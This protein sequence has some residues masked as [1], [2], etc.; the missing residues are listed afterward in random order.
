MIDATPPK[1]HVLPRRA[2]IAVRIGV[3]GL[4]LGVLVVGA[5][6][7]MNSRRPLPEAPSPASVLAT[8]EP[9]AADYA[10]AE[11]ALASGDT[12]A[13]AT[14]LAK[15]ADAGNTKARARLAEASGGGGSS[16]TTA[17]AP[18]DDAYA[19]AVADLGSLLPTS[20]P[21]YTAGVVETTTASAILSLQP[22]SDGPLGKASLVVLT[23]LDKRTPAAAK[24]Y[25]SRF[26][27]AFG[28]DLRD[29]E[30]GSLDGRFGTDGTHLAAVT[31]SRGRFAFEVV[32]TATRGVP[33]DM[34]PV[35]LQAARAFA[36]TR[37][38]Q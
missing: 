6:A 1:R 17:P 21:G 30:I 13:A 7:L 10:A 31:F 2:R 14:L 18:V 3:S 34:R 20:V 12:T 25:V 33:R 4:V 23:V 24:T 37:A 8:V 36:A 15:A 5:G 29:V 26:G 9:G 16:A 38:S 35:T 27:R 32:L 28:K 22:T 11:A 19:K